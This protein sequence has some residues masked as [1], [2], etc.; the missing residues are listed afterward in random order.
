MAPPSMVAR[1]GHNTFQN[2]KDINSVTQRRLSK[3][4]SSTA[5]PM[6]HK[7]QVA[8]S[9]AIRSNT[10]RLMQQQRLR[11]LNKQRQRRH[12][13]TLQSMVESNDSTTSSF[14]GPGKPNINIDLKLYPNIHE[15][16]VELDSV[17]RQCADDDSSVSVDAIGCATLAESMLHAVERHAAKR[18]EEER[19]A[20]E[21]QIDLPQE[22]YYTEG[23][24]PM[25]AEDGDADHNTE[26]TGERKRVLRPDVI[27]YNTAIKAWAKTA[28]SL[29]EGRGRG[30][31]RTNL[32]IDTP[33][34]SV[35]TAR[36]AAQRAQYLLDELEHDFLTGRS[37]V[38]P[39]STSYNAAIDAWAKSRT[40]EA[41]ERAEDLL[42][43]MEK[44][45]SEGAP[46]S[47]EV[48]DKE[49]TEKERWRRVSPDTVTYNAVIEAWSH[50]PDPRGIDKAI[51]IL[52]LME[53]AYETT[54]RV[55]LKPNIRTVNNVIN[56]YAKRGASG[57]NNR[58]EKESR[59][60]DAWECAKKSQKLLERS[61][62]KYVETG[63]DD[64]KPDVTTYTSVIDAY[65]RCGDVH[66]TERAEEL[67]NQ[68]WKT[69]HETGDVS[70]RPN[71]RTYTALIMAWSKTRDSRTPSR[72][73][74]L[75]EEMEKRHADSV[76]NLSN[77]ADSKGEE[78][79]KPNKIT[80]TAVINAWARSRDSN[81]AVKALR[82][83]KKMSDLYKETGD[84]RVKPNLFSYN[85]AID[86]CAKCRGTFEQQTQAL[87]IAFA[88]NKAIEA[89]DGIT[90]NHVSYGTLLKAVANLMPAGNERNVVAKAV[91]EKCK[92]AGMVEPVVI[93][94]LQMACDRELFDNL[95]DVAKD[96]FGHVDHKQIPHQWSKNVQ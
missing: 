9:A 90:A 33:D 35:Y 21:D 56:A 41:A 53:N 52:S 14:S 39:D 1:G 48:I 87:K 69:Y 40:S 85:S 70:I 36:D 13:F 46:L 92:K 19:Q 80:Y 2:N 29:A 38:Q 25:A 55:R 58:K 11:F 95:L 24:G 57:G 31:A 73:E 96:K 27:S 68:M 93:K 79:I 50:S 16:N 81:K 10:P 47:D 17:A 67:M 8:R 64:Y 59:L 3:T 78:L 62:E 74:E 32:G 61:L 88:V 83:L 30:T 51:E 42:R 49:R 22:S 7:S 66:A 45:S 28:A 89:A 5:L 37:R 34:I 63:D 4:S 43:R 84:D 26:A 12:S 71:Y 82:I 6:S 75:L 86:A 15:F 94:H 23:E 54:G 77:G 60:S 18:A 91:F 20:S 65:A 44:L 72:A 76:K